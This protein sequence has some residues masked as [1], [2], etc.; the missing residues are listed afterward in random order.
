MA[1]QRWS[2][3]NGVLCGIGHVV[4]ANINLRVRI[5]PELLQTGLIILHGNFLRFGLKSRPF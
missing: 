4:D 3:D 1:L 5:S 2:G